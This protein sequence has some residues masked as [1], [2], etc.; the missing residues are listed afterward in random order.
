MNIKQKLSHKIAKSIFWVTL[1]SMLGEVIKFITK[2]FLAR[3]LTPA[4]FGLMAMVLFVMTFMALFQEAGLESALIQKNKDIPEAADA[5]FII[6]VLIG[7]FLST[8]FFLGAGIAAKFYNEPKL[9]L[10]LKVTSP[11]FII[12]SLKTVQSGLL[13]KQFDFKKKFKAEIWSVVSYSLISIVLAIKGWG[14]W[15]LLIGY[16][17]SVLILTVILWASSSWKPTFKYNKKA[18]KSIINFSKHILGISVIAFFLLQ[19]DVAIIG[20]SLGKVWLGFYAMAYTF[21]N[22]TALQIT[23][24]LSRVIYTALCNL[25]DDK[26]KLKKFFMLSFRNTMLIVVPTTLGIFSLAKFVP[27]LLGSKWQNPVMVI[28]L[29][30]LCFF[31][32]FRCIHILCCNFMMAI[33]RPKI[34]TIVMICELIITVIFIYPATITYGITGTAFVMTFV[35]ILGSVY[36]LLKSLRYF[37]LSLKSAYYYFQAPLTAGVIM[38]LVLCSISYFF[39]PSNITFKVALLILLG[40]GVYFATIYIFFKQVIFDSLSFFKKMLQKEEVIGEEIA[41]ALIEKS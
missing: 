12:I 32:F 35:M 16:L 28:T 20:K 33:G 10:L 15:S 38:L 17:S 4:D 34:V 22:I 5:V 23:H 39:N 24:M 40:A 19:A 14:V 6:N 2:L 11:I 30:I 29:Q 21:A 9:E 27:N 41:S 36:L 13:G 7:I 3:V 37:K 31:A 1:G 26:D 8:I 25:Q 18:A